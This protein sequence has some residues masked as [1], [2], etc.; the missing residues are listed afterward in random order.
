MFD[1]NGGLAPSAGRGWFAKATGS[2]NTENVLMG[3]QPLGW[4]HLNHFWKS[5]DVLES[6]HV[7][8]V[9][10]VPEPDKLAVSIYDAFVDSGD[11]CRNSSYLYAKLLLETEIDLMIYSSTAD[12]ILGPP[13][14]EAGVESILREAV[15]ADAVAGAALTDGFNAVSKQIWFV[16][17]ATDR[18]PAGYAKCVPHKP[19]SRFCYTVVRNAGHEAPG[20]Q[21]RPAFDMIS[22]FIEGRGWGYDGQREVASCRVCSG[23]GPFAGEPEACGAPQ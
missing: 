7:A 22:R 4:G 6:W 18:Q 23:V 3:N 20:F 8:S 17:N 12:P 13:T 10:A 5:K 1:D 14:T 16:D 2:F 21:P 15:K 19:G 9:P 11:W